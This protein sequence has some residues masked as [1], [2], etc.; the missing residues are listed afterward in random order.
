MMFFS[1]LA[2]IPA[3]LHHGIANTRLMFKTKE[4]QTIQLTNYIWS[5]RRFYTIRSYLKLLIYTSYK[6]KKKRFDTRPK[7]RSTSHVYSSGTI[8]CPVPAA[9]SLGGHFKY[10]KLTLTPNTFNV[11]WNN[12][13]G[14]MNPGL[15]LIIMKSTKCNAYLETLA[16]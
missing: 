16:L 9:H 14:F 15:H 2:S 12:Q 5:V 4:L 10:Q 1:F 3:S 11:M 13:F 7:L 6:K 8:N